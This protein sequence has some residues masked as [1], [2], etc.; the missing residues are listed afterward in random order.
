MEP[1]FSFSHLFHYVMEVIGRMPTWDE[2]SRF[3]LKTERRLEMFGRE[4]H[5]KFADLVASGVERHAASK[6]LR[7]RAGNAYY[8]IARDIFTTVQLRHRGVDARCHP[9]ADTLFRFDGS[10]GRTV[11]SLRVDNRHYRDSSGG[12]MTPREVLLS[13]ATPPFPHE[14]IALAAAD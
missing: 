1:S 2:F 8:G 4:C 9:L 14:L 12:R 13:D 5:E 7:W 3:F 10:V 11:I 6:A